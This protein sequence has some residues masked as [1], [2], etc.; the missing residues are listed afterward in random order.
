M[1]HARKLGS[2]TGQQPSVA[3]LR[4]KTFRPSVRERVGAWVQRTLTAETTAE[5]IFG[6]ATFFLVTALF[7]S[8]ARALAHYTIIPLP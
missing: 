1:Q 2:F 6:S 8:F 3:P 4:V 7:V 5:V